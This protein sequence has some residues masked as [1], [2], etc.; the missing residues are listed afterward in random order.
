[1]DP[2]KASFVTECSDGIEDGVYNGRSIDMIIDATRNWASGVVLWNIA[3]DEDDGP[4]VDGCDGRCRPL[5][6]VGADGTP[7]WRPDAFALGHVSR[8][9]RPG[10]VRVES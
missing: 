2:S 7:Q 8:F 1:L 9:V 10:S 3:L 6:R 4:Y 5:V